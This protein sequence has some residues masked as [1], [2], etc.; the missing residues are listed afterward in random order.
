M[1]QMTVVV[2][3]IAKGT[4]SDEWLMVLVEEGP[5]PT[6]ETRLRAIQERLYGCIDAAI[7]GQ[8]AGEFPETYGKRVVIQLDC[9]DAPEHDVSDF[10]DR[11]SKGALATNDYRH[12]LAGSSYVSDIT[13][14]LNLAATR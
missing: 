14:K 13:F 7:D 5:W 6:V 3:V 9:Y 4:S 8:L 2:D 12:A 10:F 1:A 11:F